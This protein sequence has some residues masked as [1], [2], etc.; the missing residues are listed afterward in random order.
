MR[1]LVLLFALLACPAA[2][3]A[4][5]AAGT[6]AVP[7]TAYF[8]VMPLDAPDSATPQVVPIAANHPIGGAHPGITRAII[9]I[10][11]QTRDANAA[12]GM[13]SAL[14]GADNATTMIIA[15]QFLLPSDIARVAA[16]LP[17]QGRGIATWR[18]GDWP[19]GGNSLAARPQDAVSSYTVV[20]L[21]AM[22]ASDHDS[23]PDI[24]NIAIAG[25]GTGAV[26][27][28]RYAAFSKAI[29][30]LEQ[31][32][33]DLRFIVADAPSYLYL[34]D[35]RPP[36]PAGKGGHKGFWRPDPTQCL[37]FDDYPYGLDKL[38]PYAQRTGANAAKVNY[39]LRFITYLN[40]PPSAAD[41][42]PD[43]VPDAGCAAMLQGRD[44]ASRAA[45]FKAYMDMLYSN[46]AAKTQ[47][48]ATVPKTPDDAIG[49]F[50]SNCGMSA[51]FGDGTCPQAILG[52]QIH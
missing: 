4:D 32:N 30:A 29:D 46:V 37:G 51:L 7:A 21:L 15:P 47:I 19:V 3:A 13:M 44:A 45:L 49:L 18:A 50:G 9:V 17:N 52:P 26:F 39:A 22:Y 10:H 23:F 41:A 25:F 42:S 34:T 5:A 11:G 16:H 1:F 35:T 38:P 48:F 8:P 28:Q 12:L 27:V 14:A 20:D 33:I 6:D 2:Y 36:D 31:E 24:R 40:A 43:T